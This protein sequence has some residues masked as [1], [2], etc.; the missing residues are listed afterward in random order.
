MNFA[1]VVERI[2]DRIKVQR[3]ASDLTPEERERI[4][5]IRSRKL[6]Y[7]PVKKLASISKTC[8][9]IQEANLPGIFLEAGCALGGSAILIASIKEP[10]RPFLVYDIFGMIPPPS[11]EDTADV[12]ERY[13][14]IAEG[15]AIGIRGDE[16]YGYQDN[17]YDVV[18][19]N[20]KGF[21]ID[22]DAQHVKLVKGL[23]QE[24]L[25][26]DGPVAFAHVDVDWYDP[27]M[28]CL[29]RIFP[30]LVVGGSII[31]DDYHEWGG[32][33]KAT[34][35]YLLKVPGQFVLDDMAGS[36][37]VTRTMDPLS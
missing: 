12:H 3:L 24:T 18:Q 28:T 31:L 20:L 1:E 27:V 23:V 19:S 13:R 37:K 33:R 6:T 21:D 10:L 32:C 4:V 36:R 9:S 26:I 5:R 17:L 15:K 7:L 11:N 14:M 34:D 2:S 25:K 30:N 22:V 8:R 16:Y 29:N 35:E